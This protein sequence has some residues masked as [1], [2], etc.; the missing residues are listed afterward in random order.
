MGAILIVNSMPIVRAGLRAVLQSMGVA[1]VLHE[2]G[3]ADE[4]Q[5]NLAGNL[6]LV[7][8]DP[9]MPNVNLVQLVQQVRQQHRLV[10]LL[11]FG[12]RVEVMFASL[13]A[14]LGADG[15]VS[16]SSDEQTLVAAI[17]TLLGGM[18]CFPRMQQGLG[19]LPTKAQ[20]LSQKEME[21]LLL[22]RQGLRNKDIARKLYLSEKTISA[23]KHNILL[24]LGVTALA[25]INE[26]EQLM[27]GAS[28]AH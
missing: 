4:A 23:H 1:S 11:F 25:Q 7:I 3:S 26:P 18:Q 21:V 14:Q 27:A 15:Y 12:G 5:A 10:P 28:L 9:E 13:A 6:A 16:K 20:L 8:L 22:L 17:H 2:A 24:K 19:G